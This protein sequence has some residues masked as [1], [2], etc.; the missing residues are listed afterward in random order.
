MSNEVELR[1]GDGVSRTLVPSNTHFRAAMFLYLQLASQIVDWRG[2]PEAAHCHGHDLS[3]P[4]VVSTRYRKLMQDLSDRLAKRFRVT[5]P[6][7]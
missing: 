7:P 2:S 4:R 3:H 6:M 5:V 1:L